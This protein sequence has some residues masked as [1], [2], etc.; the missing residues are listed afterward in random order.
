VI[1]LDTNV[2]IHAFGRPRSHKQ[3]CLDILAA[4]PAL[5]EQV[6]VDVEVLQEVLHVYVLRR[7]RSDGVTVT[8]DARLI[9]HNPL[10]V[11]AVDVDLAC[12][13]ILGH[14]A[15]QARDAL[16]AAV[17]LNREAR[18]FITADKAFKEIEG[19]NPIDPAA[20]AKQLLG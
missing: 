20:F 6:N 4:V 11:S 19:L 15:L 9:F 1:L 18:A 12:D 10:P 8:R 17:A 2:L 16:H 3:P 14:P 5:E 13:L 7:Q